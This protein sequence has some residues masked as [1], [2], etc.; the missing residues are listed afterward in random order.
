MASGPTIH[1][2]RRS[3]HDPYPST[4]ACSVG[5]WRHLNSYLHS[6]RHLVTLYNRE[7]SDP[8]LSAVGAL[9]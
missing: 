7:K 1:Q 4:P 5:H 8:M 2:R 6:Q 9:D 3:C